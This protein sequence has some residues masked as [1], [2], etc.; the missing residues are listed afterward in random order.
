MK[1]HKTLARVSERPDDPVELRRVARALGNELPRAR[2]DELQRFR[3]GLARASIEN[4]SFGAGYISGILDVAAEYETHLRDQGD[5][6]TQRE[7]VGRDEVRR[8]L[9]ELRDQAARPAVLA[10]RLDIEPVEVAAM[11]EQLT[12]A[13]LVQPYAV[14]SEERHTRPYRLTRRGRQLLQESLPGVSAEVEVGIRVAINM[15]RY[16]HTNSASPASA[17]RE[18]AEELLHDPE[19]AELAAS[20][21]AQA[22]SDAGLVTKLEQPARDLRADIGGL[23]H[24]SRPQTASDTTS[25]TLWQCAPTLLARLE[26]RHSERVPVYVRTNSSGWSAWAYALQSQDQTGLSRT[27]LDGDILTQ[28]V[29]PPDRRFDLVYDSRETL[30]SDQDQPAM[31]EF[32]ERADERFLVTSS[33]DE[34]PEGFQ[35]LALLADA[36]TAPIKP[37]S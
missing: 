13:G 19:A 3:A 10:N 16:L 23:Y 33:N 31:R 8:L 36:A 20:F 28:A 4:K 1:V 2:L 32:M 18:I 29:T 9:V 6:D 12:A 22:C 37:S 14:E 24:V 27:I 35:P 15:F 25:D 21:W 5:R 30:L 34:V 26:A 17:L 7:L 11:L